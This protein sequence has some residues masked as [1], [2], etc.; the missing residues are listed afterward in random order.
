MQMNMKK[1]HLPA[2]TVFTWI[3]NSDEHRLHWNEWLPASIYRLLQQVRDEAS[4]SEYERVWI[5]NGQI[6]VRK[7]AAALRIPIA[8]EAD[9]SKMIWQ[10][11]PKAKS[12]DHSNSL[13]ISHFRINSMR[14]RI[15]LIRDF[16]KQKQPHILGITETW[17]EPT[18]NSSLFEIADYVLFRN[19][20]DI[21]STGHRLYI[22]TGSVVCY[23]PRN[24]PA[25]YYSLHPQQTLIILNF[26][27]LI[28][29]S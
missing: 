4:D 12:D 15:D 18:L 8:S 2:S 6:F 13:K 11:S 21:L 16:T 28:F 14:Y 19:D 22:W 20:R 25:K 9:L 10:S 7:T 27:F 1:G 29:L 23:V 24:S 26:W 3:L 5:R 17:L